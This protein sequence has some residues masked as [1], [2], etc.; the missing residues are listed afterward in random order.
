MTIFI[1]T[2]WWK[3]SYYY[4][5]LV[6]NSNTLLYLF[7]VKNNI[8]L[9]LVKR[10]VDATRVAFCPCD[11]VRLF[12]SYSERIRDNKKSY[13]QQNRSCVFE[14]QMSLFFSDKDSV[15]YRKAHNM[16]YK[17]RRESMYVAKTIFLTK[18][19][20]L[21]C[22]FLST[23]CSLVLEKFH[24]RQDRNYRYQYFK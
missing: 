1:F 2:Y 3:F 18:P 17:K 5:L 23:M 15:R 20:Y 21:T 11:I 19:I 10:E 4:I 7:S 8:L 24:W 22:N 16:L 6:A 14:K 9:R 12:N 13:Y